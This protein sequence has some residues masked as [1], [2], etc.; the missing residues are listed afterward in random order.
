[1]PVTRGA[2]ARWTRAK[3]STGE[4]TWPETFEIFH[5]HQDGYSFRLKSRVGDVVATGRSFPSR[6]AAKRGI[7][8]FL[9]AAAGATVV[10]T[11]AGAPLTLLPPL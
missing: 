7:A 6:D 8:A 11:T 2:R 9:T 1:M 10:P 4:H 3:E 5:D